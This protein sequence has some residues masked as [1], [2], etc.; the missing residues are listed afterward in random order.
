MVLGGQI[1]VL[2]VL[3]IAVAC[4]SWTGTEEDIFREPRD[5]CKQRSQRS[6]R[7][8]KR[9]FFYLFTCHYCFSH[10]VAA[11]FLVITQFK[12]IYADWRGYLIAFFALV[13]VANFYMS[14][15]GHLRLDI[16]KERVEI[17]EIEKQ[18]GDQKRAA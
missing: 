5:Y 12:M 3:A 8:A 16:K 6:R 14:L 2:L 4:V 17:S 11:A 18:S 9:K 15:Y 13:Y 1:V 7:L 10:Y